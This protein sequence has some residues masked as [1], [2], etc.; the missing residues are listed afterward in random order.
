V[1]AS[2][3]SPQANRQNETC[4]LDLPGDYAAPS[5]E[6]DDRMTDTHDPYAALARYYDSENADRTDDIAFFIDLT[7]Q[8][9]YPAL[10]IGCGTGRIAF[11]LAAGGAP[12]TGIDLSRSMLDIA[13]ARAARQGI[14]EARMDWHAADVRNFSLPARYRL[15]VFPYNGFMHML[16]QSDQL[17]GLARIAAHLEPGGALALDLDNPVTLFRYEDSNS[18]SFERTFIDQH[19]GHSVMQQSL[20]SLDRAAQLMHITWIYDRISDSGQVL[21]DVIPMD[22]RMTFAPEMVLLLH[23]SGFEDIS[24]YGDYDFSPYEED[25]PHMLVVATRKETG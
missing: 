2:V 8:Y 14:D 20:V 23:R 7:E 21:R 19:T 18:I 16:T 6:A 12:V 3:S 10:V 24:I 25:S 9:G 11:P 15:A 22:V 13:Q 17:A 1:T 5:V 4:M